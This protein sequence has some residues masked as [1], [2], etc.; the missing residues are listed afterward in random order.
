MTDRVKKVYWEAAETFANPSSL[1]RLGFEAE[2]CMK[3]AR[4]KV[5]DAL[6]C[7]ED[8]VFFT[9]G[10]TESNNT[11]LF[12]AARRMKKRGNRILATD[13]EHPAVEEVLK[14][15]EEEG[16]EVIR[17]S[18]KGGAVSLAQVM[19]SANEKTVLLAMMHTNNETGAVYDIASASRIVKGKNPHCL[20][21]CDGVQGFGKTLLSPARLGVDL[22]SVSSHKIHGPKG[23]GALYIRKGLV[24]PPLLLGGG[25]ERGM[26]SGTENL[27]G[28]LAFGEACAQA[29]ENLALW[30]KSMAKIKET[31]MEGLRS[32]DKVSFH[33]PEQASCHILSLSVKGL[34]SEVLLHTLSEKGIFVSSGSACSSH[35][36]R[37]PVLKHFGLTKEE[38][39]TTIR[40]SFSGL[41]TPEEGEEFVRI[42]KEVMG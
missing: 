1:H 26:R 17:L 10:G 18:T 6:F 30:Q 12:G 8:E 24:I 28:I 42:L 34:P 38:E 16:F 4:K 15:L 14:R 32:S 21:F 35:K 31:V 41:N 39:E 37:S 13:S 9:S 36:G 33:L 40:L 22:L 19:E 3:E 29:K 7:R 5:A 2:Q 20:V 25:Q 11:A 27:P 23:V